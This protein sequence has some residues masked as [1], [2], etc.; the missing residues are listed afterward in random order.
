MKSV[1]IFFSLIFSTLS[2]LFALDI[3]RA[4]PSERTVERLINSWE[5]L[6]GIELNCSESTPHDQFESITFRDGFILFKIRKID[7]NFFEMSCEGRNNFA[8]PESVEEV[9]FRYDFIDLTS[10]EIDQLK[11]RF[12]NYARLCKLSFP[13]SSREDLAN[14]AVGRLVLDRFRDGLYCCSRARQASLFMSSCAAFIK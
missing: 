4:E 6:E 1:F 14:N 2:Y 10:E 13:I 9:T 8:D 7:N 11:L 12:A 5:S 3:N